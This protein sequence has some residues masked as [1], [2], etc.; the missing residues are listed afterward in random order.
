LTPPAH[1]TSTPSP[2][3]ERHDAAPRPPTAQPLAADRIEALDA[4]RAAA[5]LAGVVLHSIAPYMHA[6]VRHLLVPFPE[7]AP[8]RAIDTVFWVI[9]ALRLPLFFFVSGFVSLLMLRRR[10]PKVFIKDRA[11]RILLPLLLTFAALFPIMYLIWGWGWVYRGWGSWDSV[12]LFRWGPDVRHNVW[13]FFHLWFLEY[14][15]IFASV[16]WCLHFVHALVRAHHRLGRI[17]GVLGS[18]WLLVPLPLAATWAAFH[19]E[20]FLDFHNLFYPELRPLIYYG[21]FFLWG[22]ATAARLQAAG[23]SLRQL[24]RAWP[25]FALLSAGACIP[26]LSI[27]LPHLRISGQ[28]LCQRA[29][30]DEDSTK[31]E[32]AGLLTVTAAAG[33]WAI[34]GAAAQFIPRLS[35]A[36][37]YLADASYW[38]YL[39]HTVWFGLGVMALHWLPWPP[40]AKAAGVMAITTAATLTTFLFVRRTRL[41]DLIGTRL[42]ARPTAPEP[43]NT[44][45]RPR[46]SAA[47]HSSQP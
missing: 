14:L 31:W 15:F 24:T 3:R 11:R 27:I 21:V 10:G 7:P 1:V 20:W 29:F 2:P 33:T 42:H 13:G 47:A 18:A 8:T 12:W 25:L 9:H 46:S 32:F 17:T 23:K 43:A 37:R 16:L 28:G 45:A 34:V 5:M 38:V 30:F 41:H 36:G 4:L 35:A 26:L 22:A 19:T 40:V 39:T 6:P 44:R